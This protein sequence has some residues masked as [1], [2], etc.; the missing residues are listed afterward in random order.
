[1]SPRAGLISGGNRYEDTLVRNERLDRA[2]EGPRIGLVA[3]SS[4]KAS[5]RCQA[6]DLYTS[7][8]FRASRAYVEATCVRW[9]V[10]S[11]KHGLL[12]PSTVIAPYDYAL[13][14]LHANAWGERIGAALDRA[15]PHETEANAE[16]VIL[17]G[18][19]YA[20]SISTPRDP[21]GEREF[22]WSE[23]LYGLGIGQ[24]LQWLKLNTP[25]GT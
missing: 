16:L 22:Y 4:E 1:M 24:R 23:P 2:S 14:R 9:Y 10:L 17:A 13:S 25:R 8:L 3:C 5:H 18:A 21:R 19:L 20:D 12:E 7:Q 15:I 11:A 6:R